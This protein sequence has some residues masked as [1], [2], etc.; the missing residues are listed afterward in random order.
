MLYYSLW[1]EPHG[2]TEGKAFPVTIISTKR[3]G[4]LVQFEALQPGSDLLVFLRC[5]LLKH[6]RFLAQAEISLS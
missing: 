5:W 3:A 6:Y 1:L 2:E 4:Q